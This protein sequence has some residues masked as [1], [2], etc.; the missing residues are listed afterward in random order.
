MKFRIGADPELFMASVDGHLKAACGRIGG[1]KQDPMPMGI[2]PG[3]MIQED[4][5]AVEFNIPPAASADQLSENLQKA[6]KE[7]SGGVKRMYN[8]EI[9][10]LS[11]A[12]FPEEELQS[13]AAR[14]FGCD[15]D[16]NAWTGKRNPRPSADDPN[17][18]SCGGHIHIGVDDPQLL[19]IRDFIKACDFFMGVPSV[20]MD[21]DG[22][23]RRIL[24]GKRG[25]Y[26]PKPV[27]GVEY[28]TLSNFWIFNKSTTDWVWRNVDRA[29]KAVEAQSVDFDGLDEAILDA[30]D[31]NN[32]NRAR[33]LI[34]K[35]D[36]EVVN[37]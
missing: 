10:N 26:R 36:L 33:E 13:D 1:T 9:V 17:L 2:G 8:F 5:V 29:L 27:Y 31:N 7:I 19:P 35:Y 14:V 28:R 34:D 20:I 6:L 4:N 32:K 24:Y 23:K 16:F 18:R 30:I 22:D 15:P 21:K 12:S 37:V 11:A 3:F 25:A